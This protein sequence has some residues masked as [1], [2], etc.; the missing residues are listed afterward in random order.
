MASELTLTVDPNPVASGGEATL[1]VSWVGLPANAMVG[2]AALWQCWNGAEWVTTHTI[3]RGW[4]GEPS[5]QGPD[6][7]VLAIGLTVPNSYSILIPDVPPGI[8]RVWDEALL[9]DPLGPPD[10][11]TGFVIVWV[12]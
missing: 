8:Y 6:V 9:T 4:A 5:V 10:T 2:I 3:H 1:S 7:P 11:V 12:R